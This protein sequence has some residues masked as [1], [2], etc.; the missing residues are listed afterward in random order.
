MSC[1]STFLPCHTETENKQA[2]HAEF[3]SASPFSVIFGLVPRVYLFCHLWA[4]PEDLTFLNGSSE[5][6]R[7]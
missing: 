5:Q 4:C 2:R 3:I 7:G 6:V 1:L